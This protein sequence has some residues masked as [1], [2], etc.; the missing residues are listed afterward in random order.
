LSL[1]HVRLTAAPA[2]GA[3][4]VTAIDVGTAMV[5]TTAPTSIKRRISIPP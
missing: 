2:C 1:A 5:A 3:S 4:V